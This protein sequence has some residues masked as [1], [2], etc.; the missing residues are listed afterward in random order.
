MNKFN[1]AVNTS[2]LAIWHV[3]TAACLDYIGIVVRVRISVS[4]VMVRV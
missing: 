1:M 2:T 4:V 3:H